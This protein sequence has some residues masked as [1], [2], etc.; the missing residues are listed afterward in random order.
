MAYCVLVPLVSV[1]LCWEERGGG[2]R[3]GVV[4]RDFG[5]GVGK[6][7]LVGVNAVGL[8]L[9]LVYTADFTL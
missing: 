9:S 6:A 7:H 2:E 8:S 5:M 1:F 4:A 3:G